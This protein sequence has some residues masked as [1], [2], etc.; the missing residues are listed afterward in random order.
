MG[1]CIST[2]KPKFDT[3]TNGKRQFQSEKYKSKR[4]KDLYLMSEDSKNQTPRKMNGDLSQS[5]PSPMKTPNDDSQ[6]Q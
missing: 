3:F 4:T 1:K 2:N 6:L 5:Y